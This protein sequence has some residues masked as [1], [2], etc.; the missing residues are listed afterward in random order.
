M[1]GL[2]VYS[3][4]ETIVL[5]KLTETMPLLSNGLSYGR[6]ILV[7]FGLMVLLADAI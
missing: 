1:E 5:S 6:G 4:E 7:F 3:N 2:Y